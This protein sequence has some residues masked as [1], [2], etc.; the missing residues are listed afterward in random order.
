MSRPAHVR[1]F[2]QGR[3]GIVESY[4]AVW[5]ERILPY[6]KLWVRIDRFRDRYEILGQILELDESGNYQPSE[7]RCR[8][9]TASEWE[10]LCTWFE[11]G[12]WGQPKTVLSPG[13]LDGEIWRITGC[14]RGDYHWVARE[15]GNLTTDVVTL[16]RQLVRLAGLPRFEDAS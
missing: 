13:C 16:G 11:R 7:I 1:R 3:R 4:E 2:L 6:E 12:F 9:V 10:Q 8:Q 14:R 15:S 5:H